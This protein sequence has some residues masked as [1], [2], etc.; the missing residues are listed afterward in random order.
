[1]DATYVR[2]TV[3]ARASINSSSRNARYSFIDAFFRVRP[4]ISC[5]WSSGLP[6]AL[7]HHPGDGAQ[8]VREDAPATDL[9]LGAQGHAGDQ[10]RPFGHRFESRVGDQHAAAVE[11]AGPIPAHAGLGD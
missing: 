11:S 10:V 2:L 6:D 1:M 7:V 9:D 8:E 3:M 4:T 5:V